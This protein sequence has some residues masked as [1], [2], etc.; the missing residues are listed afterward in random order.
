[1]CPPGCDAF[2]HGLQQ[3]FSRGNGVGGHRRQDAALAGAEQALGLADR[4]AQGTPAFGAQIVAGGFQ[5]V[6][7]VAQILL[8]KGEGIA[9]DRSRV[10]DRIALGQSGIDRSGHQQAE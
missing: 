4:A 9:E 7:E 5:A 8:L 3:S 2:A 6:L 10:L 1:M